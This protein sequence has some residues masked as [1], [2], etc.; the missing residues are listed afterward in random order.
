MIQKFREWAAKNPDWKLICDMT[1]EENESLYEQWNELPK[2]ER[3]SW[4]GRFGSEAHRAF[5]EFGI[6][7]CKVERR[8]LNEQMEICSE[9]PTG[10]AMTIYRIV[11]E[12]A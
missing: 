1:E 10:C 9:W 3:M 2:N 12:V 8:F 6:K 11:K 7:R 4:I 5:E